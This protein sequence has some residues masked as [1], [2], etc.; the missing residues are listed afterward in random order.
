MIER[1]TY[2]KACELL[3]QRYK[4]MES[5]EEKI[6]Y[7]KIG[8]LYHAIDNR[9]KRFYHEVFQD[10]KSALEWAESWSDWGTEDYYWNKMEKQE[11]LEYN[12][13][14][15]DSKYYVLN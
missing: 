11:G 12:L 15:M 5:T 7:Y 10:K 8:W 2:K 6:Y 1:I 4:D 3:K 13:K 9:D 14:Y